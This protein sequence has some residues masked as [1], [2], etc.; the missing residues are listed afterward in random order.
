MRRQRNGLERR[1]RAGRWIAALAVLVLVAACGSGD[2]DR[3]RLMALVDAGDWDAVR[4]EAEQ[5][6]QS[7]LVAPWLDYA[8]GMAAMEEGDED[9]A[10]RLLAAAAE[11]DDTL[12]API[13]KAWADAARVDYEEGWRE[14]ATARM[15]EA[16]RV[17]PATDPGELLPAVA[18]YLYRVRKDYDTAWPLY[19]RLQEERP[20][21]QRLV[22]EW[23]YRWGHLHELRGDL[24]GARAIY[25]DFIREFPDDKEQGRYAHWRYCDV[26]IEQA[27][28]AREAGDDDR[29]MGLLQAAL[30]DG[31]HIDQQQRAEYMMGQILE[32]EGEVA[33]AK[34][35]YAKVVEYGEV[36]ET[37]VVD[38]ARARLEA[39]DGEQD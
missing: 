22:P 10:R 8:D 25:E 27:R 9:E 13:A 15:A 24:D 30:D 33:R 21:P 26:L 11:T 23:V 17:D 12:A 36:V 32:S 1:C 5:L 3:Q 2:S 38:D 7:G 35:H 34:K 19:E 18:N 28:Q 39:L 20:E 29:A 4:T 16:V 6:R 31:W 37:E 14:R